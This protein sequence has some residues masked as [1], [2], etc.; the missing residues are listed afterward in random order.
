MAKFRHEIKHFISA[1]DYYTL[2]SRLSQVLKRDSFSGQDGTY[3]VT[4]LYFDNVYNKAL[5]E[6]VDGVNGRE[7]FRIRLYNGDP[8]FIKL[9]KKS[10]RNGLCRK[11]S[12]RITE[13]EVRLIS[14]GDIEWMKKSER[15]LLCEFYAKMRYIQ[16]RPKVIVSYKREAFVYTF[17]NVRITLDSDIRSGLSNTDLFDE[18]RIDFLTGRDIVLEVKF[19]EYLPQTVQ[20]IVAIEDRRAAACSKYVKCRI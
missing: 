13:E 3:K 9:E 5:F 14:R 2:R 4:S 12:E 7:K 8:S 17:G 11:K 19:D 6:K 1:S 15:P 18:S 10:K 16:L 20:H